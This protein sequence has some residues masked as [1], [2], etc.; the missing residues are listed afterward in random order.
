MKKDCWSQKN[1]QGDINEDDSN[2]AN[3]A[4]NYLQDSLILCLDNAND[5][6]V[7]DFGASFCTIPSRHLNF[8]TSLR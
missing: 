6:L 5:S 2:E 7:I 8:L 4:S 1:K 3:V